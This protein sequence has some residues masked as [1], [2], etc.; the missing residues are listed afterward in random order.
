MAR[1]RARVSLDS[2]K[3]WRPRD[4]GGRRPDG[5]V[6][7]DALTAASSAVDPDQDLVAAIAV[8]VGYTG[9]DGFQLLYSDD[10]R[11]VGWLAVA[12]YPGGRAETALR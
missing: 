4:K 8:L 3:D 9:A 5:A 1:R 6:S 7:A 12:T 10:E 11:P 2:P